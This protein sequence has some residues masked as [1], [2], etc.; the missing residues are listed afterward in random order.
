M[1]ANVNEIKRCGENVEDE[2]H[3]KDK[4]FRSL[5]PKFEY[6]TCVFENSNNLDT[7]AIDGLLGL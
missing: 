3:A 7:I 1:L 2:Y 5:S 4:I 6:L